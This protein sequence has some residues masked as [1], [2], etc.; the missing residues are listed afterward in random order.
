MQRHAL[1]LFF[2]AYWHVELV[3]NAGTATNFVVLLAVY[4]KSEQ[5]NI[6]AKTIRGLKD[7]CVCNT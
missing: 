4:A 2:L 6:S 7:E 5:E 1:A 3:D